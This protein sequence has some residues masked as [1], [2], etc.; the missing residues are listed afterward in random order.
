RDVVAVPVEGA[1]V[2][3]D[4]THGW[5]IPVARPAEAPFATAGVIVDGLLGTGASG[6]PRAA[7]GEM[8][9]AMNAAGRPIL[10]LDGP[11]GVD[12]TSGAVPGAAVRAA[13]TVTF[14]AVKRGL[15]LHPG[16]SHAG[17]VRLAEVGF[18][19]FAEPPPAAIIV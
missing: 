9:Q 14:G 11:S 15:L 17:R 6:A 13:T 12:L 10:A 1:R 5:R 2:P 8:I 4:L 16:R 7:Y 19:P 3:D 18:P